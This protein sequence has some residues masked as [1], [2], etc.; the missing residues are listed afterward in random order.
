MISRGFKSFTNHCVIEKSPINSPFAK[1][2]VPIRSV[3]FPWRL[4]VPGQSDVVGPDGRMAPVQ[5]NMWPL[6][7][8]KDVA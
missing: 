2:N 4:E 1:Q 5:D 7:S 8:S 6:G 3:G